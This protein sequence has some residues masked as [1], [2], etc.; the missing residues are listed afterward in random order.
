LNAVKIHQT[1]GIVPDV[2]FMV[3]LTMLKCEANL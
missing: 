1:D 3:M 2:N